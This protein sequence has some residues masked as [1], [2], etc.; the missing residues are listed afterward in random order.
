MI[1][2]NYDPEK[3]L[4][5]NRYKSTAFSVRHPLPKHLQALAKHSRER[6]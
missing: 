5:P 6:G 4:P 2:I 3:K 1:K